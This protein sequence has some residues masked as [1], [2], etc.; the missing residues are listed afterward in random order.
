MEHF[1][2]LFLGKSSGG[3]PQLPFIP[4]NSSGF[5]KAAIWYMVLVG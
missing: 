2:D 3:V 1:F 4:R 5:D